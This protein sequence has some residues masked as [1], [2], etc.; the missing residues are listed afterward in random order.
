MTKGAVFLDTNILVAASHEKVNGHDRARMLV[1][2]L[3][4]AH[5]Q[6]WVSR[7][8]LREFLVTLT[9]PQPY[10]EPVDA[11]QAA[12]QCR[13][14]MK[15]CKI[16]EDSPAISE[17]LIEMVSK[18]KASGKQIHDANIVATMMA[19]GIKAVATFDDDVFKRFPEEIELM[20]PD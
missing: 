19:H 15:L 18:G 11:G 7:Q 14:W 5:R 1:E 13:R 6:T 4:A 2:K 20:I 8:V 10:G 16:A 12:G 9:R 3:W 17:N